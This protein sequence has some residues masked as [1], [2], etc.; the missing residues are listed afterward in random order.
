MWKT[1]TEN[2][3]KEMSNSH[4]ENGFYENEYLRRCLLDII[5][6]YVVINKNVLKYEVI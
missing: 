3:Q 6:K 2:T 5:K 1:K 4:F